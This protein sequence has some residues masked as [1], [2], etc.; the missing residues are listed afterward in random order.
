MP[1]T[2]VKARLGKITRSGGSGTN[3]SELGQK[4][5]EVS[6]IDIAVMVH[7]AVFIGRAAGGAK[8]GQKV[9]QVGGRHM[10]V[11]VQVA[12]T[13]IWIYEYCRAVAGRLPA[14]TRHSARI[15]SGVFNGKLLDR[16]NRRRRSG[17]TAKAGSVPARHAPAGVA[18]SGDRAHD[19]SFAQPRPAS[20]W[21]WTSEVWAISSAGRTARSS[22]LVK[23][24]HQRPIFLDRSRHCQP[25]IRPDR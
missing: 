4:S 13:G 10:I 6:K 21:P 11:P 18:R 9:S 12:R 19:A 3:C 20:A 1:E 14:H 15:L 23:S 2:P 24:C 7:V 17:R 25:T 16:Q 8:M 5:G 22:A